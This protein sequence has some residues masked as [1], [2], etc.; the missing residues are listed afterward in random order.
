MWWFQ[1]ERLS[2]VLAL[3]PVRPKSVLNDRNVNAVWAILQ[4]NPRMTCE[5][6]EASANISKTSIFGILRNNLLLCH[7]CSSWIPHH[8]TKEQMQTR[9]NQYCEWKQM[10]Q[11]DQTF[12][13][14][15]MNRWW[16]LAASFWPF[17]RVRNQ[18]YENISILRLR[19]KSDKPNLLVRLWWL[20]SFNIKM[21]SISMQCIQKPLWMVNIS[22][23]SCFKSF[24]ITHIESIISG[25]DY[26]GARGP[27]PPQK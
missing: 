8:L 20:F 12:L 24:A 7:V 5:E 14:T 26:V 11:N 3:K 17:Y 18:V 10:L 6:I 1:N 23:T 4:E 21:Q 2:A 19:K 27:K 22:V 13:K 15:V 16:N 25:A 9:I